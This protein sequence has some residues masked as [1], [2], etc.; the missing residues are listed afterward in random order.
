MYKDRMFLLH[1]PSGHYAL[2]SKREGWGWDDVTNNSMTE[3][4]KLFSMVQKG[5]LCWRASDQDCF[6]LALEGDKRLKR[7]VKID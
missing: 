3:I 4:N 2:I 1:V 5:L 7:R 6:E